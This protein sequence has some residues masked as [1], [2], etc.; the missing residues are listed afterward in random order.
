[1]I[2]QK[3]PLAV[4]VFLAFNGGFYVEV[5]APAG[6]LEAVVT[7]FFGQRGELLEW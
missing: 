6:E 7:H 2:L 5:I 3:L 4:D 1:M